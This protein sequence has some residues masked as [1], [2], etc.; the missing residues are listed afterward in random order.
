ML[1]KCI[2]VFIL[3]S[4]IIP[5]INKLYFKKHT[6]MKNSRAKT[7]KKAEAKPKKAPSKSPGRKTKE[8]S[9]QSSTKGKKGSKVTKNN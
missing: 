1:F 9:K 4:L 2:Y 6:F 8:E 3:I 5:K 7:P